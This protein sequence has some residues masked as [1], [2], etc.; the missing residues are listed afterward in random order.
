MS[1]LPFDLGLCD[2][3]VRAMREAR[4]SR[5]PFDRDAALR[6]M[7]D[8]APLVAAAVRR[9]PVL[10]GAPFTLPGPEKP[11]RSRSVGKLR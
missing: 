5:L 3:D 7:A 8:A 9:R 6:L 10:S 1:A 11:M 2:D 4:R